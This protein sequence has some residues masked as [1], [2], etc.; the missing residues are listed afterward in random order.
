MSVTDIDDSVLAVANTSW[1]KVAMVIGRTAERLGS[2][3]P[4]GDDGYHL[5]AHRIQALVRDGRL[6]A[7]GNVSNWRH[8]EVRLP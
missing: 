5:I 2:T 1:R 4:E 3:L 8:S 6:L 7:Q